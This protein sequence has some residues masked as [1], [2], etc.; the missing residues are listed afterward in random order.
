MMKRVIEEVIVQ[1]IA[2]GILD[3][4]AWAWELVKTPLCS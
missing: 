3:V 1:L 2:Q 4:M